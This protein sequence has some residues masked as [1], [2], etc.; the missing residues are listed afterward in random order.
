M[1]FLFPLLEVAGT[2]GAARWIKSHRRMSG[3]FVFFCSPAARASQRGASPLV[4][5]QVGGSRAR[6]RGRS[7]TAP[8]LSP[9]CLAKAILGFRMAAAVFAPHARESCHV[10]QIGRVHNCRSES[11]CKFASCAYLRA[12]GAM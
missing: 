2:A 4:P 5:G 9:L 11:C 12:A 3:L 8:P 10:V 1:A 6:C 7:T